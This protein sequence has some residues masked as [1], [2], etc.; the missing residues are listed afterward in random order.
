MDF[1]WM[2]MEVLLVIITVASGVIIIG[3][4]GLPRKPLDRSLELHG[5]Q[6]ESLVEVIIAATVVTH[7]PSKKKKAV[8]VVH[9]SEQYLEAQLPQAQA[10]K[11]I[12]PYQ[13]TVHTQVPIQA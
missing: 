12:S 2:V 4:A 5:T 10:P 8:A 6:E 1:S 13:E 3:G 9:L 11:R 7:I